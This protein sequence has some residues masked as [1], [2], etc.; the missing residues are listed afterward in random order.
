MTGVPGAAPL[1]LHQGAANPGH[2]QGQRQVA[3]AAVQIQDGL[4]LSSQDLVADRL[5]QQLVHLQVH[6]VEAV[7]AHA[8]LHAAHPQG[9]GGISSPSLSVG[10][11]GQRA[12]WGALS[13]EHVDHHALPVAAK[14]EAIQALTRA[15]LLEGRVDL[16]AR[17][18]VAAQRI[19]LVGAGSEVADGLVP[20]GVLARVQ[21][22][23]RAIPELPRRGHQVI[24]FRANGAG[25]VLELLG[26]GKRP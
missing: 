16:G 4:G 19:Q 25:E 12:S 1:T 23:A 11:I 9:Q 18:R 8:V 14:L 26:H 2:G 5:D 3:D 20:S 6:L 13:L 24:R 15:D 7:G 21:R 10:R 17:K 22:D